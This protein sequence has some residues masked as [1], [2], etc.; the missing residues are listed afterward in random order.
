MWS[1]RTTASPSWTPLLVS[2]QFPD[3]ADSGW[4]SDLFLVSERWP[5]DFIHFNALNYHLWADD[6]HSS[7]VSCVSP[8][9]YLTGISGIWYLKQLC[10][11][12]NQPFLYTFL[13]ESKEGILWVIQD[14]ALWALLFFL[15]SSHPTPNL[16]GNSANLNLSSCSQLC[17]YLC[18][19]HWNYYYNS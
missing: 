5:A 11:L 16:P 15:I 14:N 18:C 2:H 9:G 7:R 17:I 4:S 3:L 1:H 12:P 6:F 13:T 8:W 10:L 19:L